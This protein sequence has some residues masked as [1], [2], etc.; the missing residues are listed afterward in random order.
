MLA[1]APTV[2]ITITGP[3]LVSPLEITEPSVVTQ[4]GA[5]SDKLIPGKGDQREE[6]PHGLQPY[7]VS[8]FEQLNAAGDQKCVYVILFYHDPSTGASFI[9]IPDK[10]DK[11]Y[12]L[13]IGTIWRPGKDGM[14]YN[15]SGQ[16]Q[17]IW[18]LIERASLGTKE[19]WF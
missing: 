10:G 5:W 16:W 14:W 18:P 7:E 11:W 12:G 3:G 19:R 15:A 4:F 1:K 2:R 8:L 9:H 6:P 17:K 13:N